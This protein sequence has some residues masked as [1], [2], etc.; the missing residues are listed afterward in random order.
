[1]PFPMSFERS[2][3]LAPM[4][5]AVAIR[6]IPFEALRAFCDARGLHEGDAVRCRS[7][8]LRGPVVVETAEGR[9]VVV[10]LEYATLI[11]CEA[12]RAD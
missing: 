6:R 11:E 10:P 9:R 3:A 7:S 4:E 2:L 1:M 12:V 8:A 5:T